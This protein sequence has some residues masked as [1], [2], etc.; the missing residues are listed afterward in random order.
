MFDDVLVSLRTFLLVHR[1]GAKVQNHSVESSGDI[2]YGAVPI[3]Q[4]AIAGTRGSQ[5][6]SPVFK[7]SEPMEG[8]G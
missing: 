2:D 5:S 8:E 1:K 3:L 7:M 4:Y 6:S